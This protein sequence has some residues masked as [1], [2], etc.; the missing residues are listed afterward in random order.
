M[1]LFFALPLPP[2]IQAELAALRSDVG[3]ARWAREHQLHVTLR[4]IGEVDEETA[5]RV[6]ERVET[7]C[8]GWS[9]QMLRVRGVGIFGGLRRARVLWAALEDGDRLR[10]IA[11]D[12]ETSV[13]EVGLPPD[14]RA[15][16]AHITLARITRANPDALERF[17]RQHAGFETAPFEVSE[18]ILYRSVIGRDGAVHEPLRRFELTRGRSLRD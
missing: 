11:L 16:A 15:F 10:A 2:S 9:V 14:E 8:T 7:R 6:I 3:K 4:F 18:V 5:T 13:R 12:L 1:R 17:L